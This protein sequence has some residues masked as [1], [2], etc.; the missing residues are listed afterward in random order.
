[1]RLSLK[2]SLKLS[3]PLSPKRQPGGD[4]QPAEGEERCTL[5]NSDHLAGCE[6]GRA[7][8]VQ[9]GFD[10]HEQQ[11]RRRN[12]QTAEQT[13]Q[14]CG[15]KTAVLNKTPARQEL[16]RAQAAKDDSKSDGSYLAGIFDREPEKN[17]G[18]EDKPGQP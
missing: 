7:V 10:S 14:E 11:R 6:I 18:R 3:L 12:R 9:P 2:L 4:E 1:M 16:R 5:K 8:P 13:G 17:R 15:R